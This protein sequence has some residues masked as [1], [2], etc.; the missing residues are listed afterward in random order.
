MTK[1]KTQPMPTKTQNSAPSRLAT[2]AVT[3]DRPGATPSQ[4]LNGSAFAS[5]RD[6]LRQLYASM[7]KCRLAAGNA[8]RLRRHSQL[9]ISDLSIG[10]GHEA[11]VA[12]ASVDLGPQDSLLV[13]PG[14]FAAHILW[15]GPINHWLKRAGLGDDASASCSVL[16]QS[17]HPPAYGPGDPAKLGAGIALA[18]K[19]EKQGHVAVAL[20]DNISSL[21]GWHEAFRFAGVHK[22]PVIFVVK[23]DATGQPLI[24]RHSDIFEDV[25]LMA[26]D[27]GFPGIIVDGHDAVA[28]WRVAHESIQRAR[29]GSGPTLIECQMQSAN[30]QDPL[31]HL[32][33]YMKKRGLWDDA[34]KRKIARQLNAEIAQLWS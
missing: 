23:S 11:V 4:P 7:L 18:H 19:L 15:G 31:T 14:N 28:V 30:P 5:S 22:L 33:H 25:G 12:G 20:C 1:P 27:Y 6:I 2:P 32:E 29:R 26:R 16:L 8:R 21:E 10:H 9:T 3:K 34:W 17:S 13:L 24:V